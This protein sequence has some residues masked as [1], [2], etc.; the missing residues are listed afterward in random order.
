M[1]LLKLKLTNFQGVEDFT[2]EPAGDDIT[3]LGDNATGKTTL[4]NAFSWLLFGKDSLGQASFEIKPLNYDGSVQHGLTTEV[5][6]VLLNGTDRQT[7]LRKTYSEKYTKK[8]GSAQAEL[9]GH[10]INHFVDGVPVK[11]GEFQSAVSRL[12]DESLFKLLTNP[13]YFNEQC[14]WQKRREMLLSICGDVSDQDVIG[15][16][17][18]LSDLPA[19]LNGRKLEDH[20][21]V[22]TANRTEI[23]KQLQEIPPRIDEATRSKT[24]PGLMTPQEIGMKI[25]TL[26]DEIKAKRAELSRMQNGGELAEK[27]K[28]LAELESKLLD[29]DNQERS[30]RQGVVGVK[31]AKLASLVRESSDIEA[32]I[33]G[34]K[35]LQ[36]KD[37]LELGQIEE[38]I[39]RLREKFEHESRVELEYSESDTCP[40]CK[41]RL[42]V[43]QV[44]AALEK[45]ISDFN[46]DKAEKLRAINHAGK[47][48][49]EGK[50]KL[51][52]QITE[53]KMLIH[54]EEAILEK[55][56]AKI[57][58]LKA[59][60]EVTPT[61]PAELLAE[62]EKLSSG[63]LILQDAIAQLESA[64]DAAANDLDSSILQLEQEKQSWQSKLDTFDSNKKAEIRI[65]DLKKQE[66]ALAKEY[67]SVEKQL[68]LC[69]L[70]TR[71]KVGMLNDK[72]NSYFELAQ[73]KLFSEQINGGLAECC[74]V[75]VN[76]V[77]Y[78][79]LNNGARTN[80]GLDII[81][82][83]SRHH[84]VSAPIFCD[85]AEAVT[86]LLH[87]DAQQISLVVSSEHKTL[88]VKGA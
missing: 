52:A 4:A 32:E 78:S 56:Q 39:A 71:I 82:T 17:E 29:L 86:D 65:E 47:R 60:L 21:K 43:E 73:W 80:V 1:R 76:G 28:A 6:A 61:L 77:P 68:Y 8:R 40:T 16:C 84:G 37:S 41:Q 12:C 63:R 85:N 55:L 50:S 22:L 36:E 25:A 62:R 30:A 10:D 45:A 42:P 79:S 26:T 13:R 3:I 59:E 9:T 2:L 34:A 74:E 31:E 11:A 64:P 58:G 75:T 33:V 5:E 7:I 72:I 48:T 46:A 38:E 35:R 49:A 67:E 88:T 57:A 51:S 54:N 83:L 70:F 20:K 81:N 87:T 69:E 24:D 44:K 14:H 66:R 15:G 53:R 19:I 18:D 27:R 23:N